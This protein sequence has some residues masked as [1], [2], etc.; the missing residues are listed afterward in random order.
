MT[1][2]RQKVFKIIYLAINILTI[3]TEVSHAYNN[4]IKE[5]IEEAGCPFIDKSQLLRRNLCLMPSYE[6]YEPPN[7][8]GGHT[9]IDIDFWKPPKILEVDEKNNKITIH[10]LQLIEWMDSRVKVN[11]TTMQNMQHS[12]GYIKFIPPE[13]E[14]IWHPNLD[15]YTDNLD[16]WKSLYDPLW[17]K[18]VGVNKCPWLRDCHPSENST[19]MFAE[20][21]WR[22][23][24]FCNFDFSLFPF[25]TQHC[26]FRQMFQSSSD[27]IY[28]RL[29]PPFKSSYAINFTKDMSEWKYKVAGFEATLTHIGTLIESGQ[30]LEQSGGDFGFDIELKRIIL[31]YLLQYYFP[32][33]SI[34]VVSQISF[35]IPLSS[36]PGRVALMVTQFLT[37]TQIFISQMVRHNLLSRK[38]RYL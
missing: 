25:D 22:V 38:T 18:N 11:T 27:N 24:I 35:M 1:T 10:L 13:V 23:T 14:R 32:C 16:D 21:D 29:Y 8:K 4:N 30:E 15:L 9:N 6:L 28:L 7:D 34:V 33:A 37:L 19:F 20:K 26:K 12:S 2:N 31:P 36:I 17:F 3:S 5:F